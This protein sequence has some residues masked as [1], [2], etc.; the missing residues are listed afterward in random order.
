MVV[1]CFMFRHKPTDEQMGLTAEICE[2]FRGY[3]MSAAFN[4]TR[5][6]TYAED[7]VQQTICKIIMG[8][9]KLQDMPKNEL[10]YYMYRAALNNAITYMSDIVKRNEVFFSEMPATETED[11]AMQELLKS[12]DL[13]CLKRCLNKL[14]D[15]QKQVLVLAYCRDWST[16]EISDALSIKQ[17][18]VRAAKKR[19]LEKMQELWQ[20]EGLEK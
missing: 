5:N 8:K 18:G 4:V 7:V 2:Q 1:N 11:S 14:S 17:V 6:I 13:N 16:K 15:R 9:R 12:D 10:K 3:M 19:G 20:Q